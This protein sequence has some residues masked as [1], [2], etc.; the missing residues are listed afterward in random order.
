[1]QSARFSSGSKL[2]ILQC[3]T[4]PVL[5]SRHVIST[6][7]LLLSVAI[8]QAAF[9]HAGLAQAAADEAARL[10]LAET[11]TRAGQYDR[12]IPLLESLY[13]ENPELAYFTRLVGALE[14][15]K[16]YVEAIALIDARAATEAAPTLLLA[17]KARLLYMD[18]RNDEAAAAWQEAISVAPNDEMSYRLVYQSIAE[19]REFRKAADVLLQGRTA[20]GD[21]SLFA[22]ELGYLYGMLS[23]HASA[24][25]EYLSLIARDERQLSNVKSRLGR[26]A[27]QPGVV[28]ASVRVV[29][30]AVGAEPGNL[31]YREL[32]GWL[33]LES[34]LFRPALDAYRAIDRLEPDQGRVLFTFAGQAAAAEAFDVALEAYFDI[35]K[36]HADLP[37][38]AEALRG[39]AEMHRAWARVLTGEEAEEQYE[40]ALDAFEDYVEKYPESPNYPYVMLDIARLNQDVF[41]R[42]EPAREILETIITR[43]PSHAAADHAEYQ[44]GLLLLSDGDLDGAQVQLERLS[45]RLG[46]GDLAES[47]RYQVAM[48]H[49]YRGEFDEADKLVAALKENTSDDTANDAIEMRVLLVEGRGPDS[50]STPLREY[51]RAQML[52]RQRTFA[53]A[54]ES[55]REMQEN[56]PG[57]PL[58][59]DAM[60]EQAEL[61]V[62]LDR[63]PEA[64][65]LYA[66]LPLR[67]PKSHLADHS[68][69]QAATLQ[70]ARLNNVDKAI[71]LYNRIMLE[72]PGSILSG[73]A[74]LR[75]RALRGDNV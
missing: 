21:S 14:S 16:R 64:Y 3:N 33:Y 9:V 31:A 72:Y 39:K 23:D 67:H 42:I 65:Q 49:F 6:G 4:K 58:A 38:A 35:L 45:E 53:E 74:R 32:L 13:A 34:G 61:L 47:S 54:F 12:A 18:R 44:Y 62:L 15:T 11:Y 68:L 59:D 66:E 60:F 41:F 56:H 29:E 19:V 43:F 57:H 46:T 1:M 52:V 24:M 71:E 25:T 20:L 30:E 73:E 5:K 7:F 8:V 28:A 55:F 40:R 27:D 63:I 51:A 26:V 50:L 10:Q 69:F 22:G 70:E 48:I 36:E 17:Q 75:I 2:T 37:I